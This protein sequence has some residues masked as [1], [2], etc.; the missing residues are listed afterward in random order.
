[1]F[2]KADLSDANLVAGLFN[3]TDFRDA[4]LFNADVRL[5]TFERVL[6]KGAKLTGVRGLGE[7]FIKS[8]NIGTPE[9]PIILLGTEAKQWLQFKSL[10]NE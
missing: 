2:V 1:V 4:V 9:H 10:N 8:I 5:A 7:A 3:E 6:L